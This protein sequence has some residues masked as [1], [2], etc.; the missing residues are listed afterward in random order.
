M[1]KNWNVSSVF[2]LISLIVMIIG[3]YFWGNQLVGLFF[4]YAPAPVP[5]QIKL[6]APIAKPAQGLGS[7]IVSQVEN[8]VGSKLPEANP[9]SAPI[10]PFEN[11]YKNPFA[12]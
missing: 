1:E 10:N 4:S 8:P 3:V 5:L 9:F 7:D 12:Q 6:K 11:I 2:I